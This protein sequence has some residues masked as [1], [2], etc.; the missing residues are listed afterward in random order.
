MEII[1]LV[2]VDDNLINDENDLNFDCVG[3]DVNNYEKNENSKGRL[4]SIFNIFMILFIF[5]LLGPI[6]LGMVYLYMN[7]LKNGGFKK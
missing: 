1:A 6:Y 3:E 4:K 5:W 7:D 2:Y